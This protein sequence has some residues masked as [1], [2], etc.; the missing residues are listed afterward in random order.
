VRTV[1]W[2]DMPI[3][4]SFGNIV[5]DGSSYCIDAS[6]NDYSNNGDNIQL[7]G[8]TGNPGQL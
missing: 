2:L 7:W 8:C 1:A 3:Y 4:P 5:N 6:S